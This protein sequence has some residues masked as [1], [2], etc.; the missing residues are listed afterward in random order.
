MFTIYQHL[1]NKQ[2]MF[3]GFRDANKGCIDIDVENI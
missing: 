3:K 2:H 1:N